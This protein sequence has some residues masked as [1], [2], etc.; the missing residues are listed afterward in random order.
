MHGQIIESATVRF[1]AVDGGFGTWSMYSGPA[2][3]TDETIADWGIKLEKFKALVIFEY[4]FDL[5]EYR[6]R[7]F[8]MEYRD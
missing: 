3:A 7:W 6:K 2:W 5:E 4:L 8:A 1:V